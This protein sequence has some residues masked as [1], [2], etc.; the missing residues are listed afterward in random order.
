MSRMFVSG[1]GD[2][3]EELELSADVNLKDCE[4]EEKNLNKENLS[5]YVRL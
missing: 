5:T 4:N 1:V 3:S 2:Q